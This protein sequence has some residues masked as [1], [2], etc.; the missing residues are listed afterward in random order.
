MLSRRVGHT[1]RV[2]RVT[3]FIPTYNRAGS[4]RETLDTVLAQTFTD[5]EVLVM[6][7]GSKDDTAGMVAAIGDPRIRYEW[8]PNSGG[9]ATP[10]NRGI[11][12]AS[13]DWICFLDADDFWYPDKLGTMAR[14]IA[15]YAV[16]KGRSARPS[17]SPVARK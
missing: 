8:A 5:F 7:D 3:V 10:R 14:T 17:S 2:P 12:A 13:A 11:E 4:L 16:Y 1:L 15:R 9:P 6:D